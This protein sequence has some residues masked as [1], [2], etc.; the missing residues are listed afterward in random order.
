MR[1]CVGARSKVASS[2]KEQYLGNDSTELYSVRR[3]HLLV[4]HNFLAFCGDARAK[5][6]P[7]EQI[8]PK[9]RAA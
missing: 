8:N 1:E 4:R 7:K 3:R 5:R 6:S 2:E 9:Q